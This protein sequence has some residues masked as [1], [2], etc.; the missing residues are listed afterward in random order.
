MGGTGWEVS[1]SLEAHGIH[2]LDQDYSL[3]PSYRPSIGFSQRGCRLKCPFCVVPK[4]E[5]AIRSERTINGIWRGE[6][7]PRQIVLLDNDFF[8]QPN[9]EAR[10][11]ELQEGPFQVCFSQGINARFLDD[12]AAAAIAAVDYRD[13]KFQR[14]QVYTAWD[15][16]KDEHRLFKGLERLVRYGVKPA[17]IMVYMLIGYWEGETEEDRIHRQARLREFGAIPYPMPFRRTRDLV[18]FQRWVCG[19]YDKRIPWA[20]WKAA[21]YRPEKLSR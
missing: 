11:L 14:R 12:A 9:W 4:K 10:V 6:P 13:S 2:T 7:H 8:G 17:H 20:D 1:S 21:N 16:R 15:N 5:G 19:A 3:Y 18:G